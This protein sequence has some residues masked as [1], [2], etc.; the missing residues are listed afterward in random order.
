MALG[1]Q[2]AGIARQTQAPR[3]GKPAPVG[4][5]GEIH[6]DHGRGGRQVNIGRV[7]VRRQI[8][9]VAIPG[10]GAKARISYDDIHRNT[11]FAAHDAPVHNVDTT[12]I[13]VLSP[14]AARAG[15]FARCN[16][17]CARRTADR[18]IPACHKRMPGQA[19]FIHIGAHVFRGPMGQRVHLD[20]G[21]AVGLKEFKRRAGGALKPFAPG[22]P[23][24]VIG[25]GTLQGARLAQVTAGVGVK[26]V[27]RAIRVFAR[28]LIFGG[29]NDAHVFQ[30][31]P[32]GQVRLIG[33]RFGKQH[34]RVDEHNRR[35][36]VDHRNQMQQ[37]HRFR[38]KGRHER[39][40]TC[41]GVFQRL[42]QDRNR[43]VVAVSVVQGGD[44]GALFSP[45]FP[46]EIHCRFRHLRLP[47][48][49]KAR[50]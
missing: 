26:L 24:I 31:Q 12:F 19:V 36:A 18:R 27:Q 17:R 47:F 8:K 50:P 21:G 22:D 48:Q 39:K 49:D 7:R 11:P 14:P 37:H 5:T 6:P 42:A 34:L 10:V 43:A 46:T 25:Q 32:F 3:N 40:P 1:A 45:R 9:D 44:P 30:A 15:V 29:M 4:K 23:A 38:T 13:F 28:N 33:Q 41:L 35:R 2:L 20:P 16:G